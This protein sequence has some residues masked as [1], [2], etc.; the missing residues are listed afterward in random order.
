MG[1]SIKEACT[2]PPLRANSGDDSDHRCVYAEC[3]LGQDKDFKWVV[4]MTR[5]RNQASEEAFAR[6]LATWELDG[7]QEKS[8]D[9]VALELEMNC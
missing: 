4:K 8:V 7:S 2:L 1:D 3:D 9:A 5:R 6:E